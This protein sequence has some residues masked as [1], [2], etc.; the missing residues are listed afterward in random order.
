LAAGC[1]DIGHLRLPG[2]KIHG[3]LESDNDMEEENT[4]EWMVLDYQEEKQWIRDF[5]ERYE[6]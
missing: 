6:A 3:E 5:S 1:G 2:T 4:P